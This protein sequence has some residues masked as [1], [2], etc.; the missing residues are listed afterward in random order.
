MVRFTKRYKYSRM[1]GGKKRRRKNKRK[2][3]R[4]R[5]GASNQA[6]VECNERLQ[7]Q[8]IGMVKRRKMCID[9]DGNAGLNKQKKASPEQVPKPVVQPKPVV[10]PVVAPVIAPVI[11]QSRLISNT[12]FHL[13]L[14]SS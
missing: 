10:A 12:P 11:A 1:N 14:F 6:L 4:K 9:S 3:R 7:K 13:F 2:T 8:N 5:G